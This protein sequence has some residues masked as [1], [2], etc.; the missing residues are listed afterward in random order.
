MVYVAVT[1]N[2][3]IVETQNWGFRSRPEAKVALTKLGFKNS[4]GAWT[5][6]RGRVSY[7]AIIHD[8]AHSATFLWQNIEKSAAA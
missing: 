5:A 3:H 8:V 6:S 2:K 4:N 7:T 1:I